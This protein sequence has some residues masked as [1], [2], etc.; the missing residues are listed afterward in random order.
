MFLKKQLIYVL[1]IFILCIGSIIPIS[2][3][4]ETSSIS[5]PKSHIIEDVPYAAQ[6]DG[7]CFFASLEMIYRFYG[8]ETD[9][10]E[11]ATLQGLSYNLVYQPTL[12]SKIQRPIKMPPYKFSFPS[13]LV[14]NQGNDD[15]KFVGN[16][17]GFE[18]ESYNTRNHDFTDV[19]R[20][21]SYWT[22]LKQQISKDSPLITCVDYYVWP[23]FL[24]LSSLPPLYSLIMRGAHSI[25]IVGY[26]ENNRTVC[27]ND[28][29]AGQ[30]NASEKGTYR[31]VPISVFRKAVRRSYWDGAFANYDMYLFEK[32]SEPL[33]KD[34]IFKICHERNIEKMKGNQS[35]YDHDFIT[36]NFEKYG[37]DAWQQIKKDYKN[38]FLPFLPMYRLINK[39]TGMPFDD[40]I[41][42]YDFE[43]DR[44]IEISVYLNE[45]KDV[46]TN[47]TLKNISIYERDLFYNKSIKI[48]ELTNLAIDLKD[49]VENNTIFKAYS[50]S[51]PIIEDICQKIDE[52][53]S[54][55]LEIIAGPPE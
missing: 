18:I 11:L 13:S 47:Q 16:L 26:N 29:Y 14:S 32:T 28:P 35:A 34:E 7:H 30:C 33:S 52:I 17:M 20:W 43:V 48:R 10:Y 22:K 50:E 21:N 6:D 41:L 1:F 51:R 8:V 27:V 55:E 12:K 54:I 49:A 53:I 24:E 5:I 23:I 2:S 38:H 36:P 45:T 40:I 19:G 37:V 31:W 3:S 42:A 4:I 39:F 15:I 44:D 25:V 9:Q 46:L